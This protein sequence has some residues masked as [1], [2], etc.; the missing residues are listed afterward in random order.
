MD[1]S[2]KKVLWV[3]NFSG[4]IGGGGVWMF[5][6]YEFMKEYADI[7]YL[8]DLRNPIS[9]LRHIIHLRKISSRYKVV[10]AQYGS[11]VAFIVSFARC[12]KILSLKGSDWYISPS[13][14]I[15]NKARIY[16]GHYLTK[17]SIRRF[18]SLIVMSEAMKRQI[19]K[20][21]SN[22]EVN[23]LVDPIDLDEFKPRN[24]TKNKTKK[25][26]FSAVDI[27]NPVKRFELAQQSVDL[28]KKQYPN[29]ELVQMTNI[30]HSEVSEFINS[31]DVLLL[32]STH[33]GWPNIVKEALACNKPF[34][35]T[36]VSDLELIAKRANC[37]YVCEPSPE[38]LSR[39]LYESLH[40]QKED[41]RKFV[42]PFKMESV[43]D[44]QL[45]IYSQLD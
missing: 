45:E 32:T 8:N 14:S 10:H 9:F 5:N 39:G 11:A 27:N 6:Q 2:K 19:K 21:Y 25:I 3:H 36:N 1:V 18:D 4:K 34:V 41:L 12:R 28:L 26:L 7:Y 16:I 17:L 37:C 33:E 24:V 31:I 29:V 43:I 13:P 42:L 23:V 15:L 30:P 20:Q 38:D 35:S 44:R 40:C 22:I